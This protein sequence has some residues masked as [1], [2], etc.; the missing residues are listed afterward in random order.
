[1]ESATILTPPSTSLSGIL[2]SFIPEGPEYD[3]IST[4]YIN[5]RGEVLPTPLRNRSMV[6]NL[7]IGKSFTFHLDFI[8]YPLFSMFNAKFN[9]LLLTLL[10]TNGFFLLV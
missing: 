3:K 10:Y 9:L 8:S 4:L 6:K 7:I 2:L 1:M 5:A